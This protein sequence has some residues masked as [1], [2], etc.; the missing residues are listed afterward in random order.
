M[1]RIGREKKNLLVWKEGQ[2]KQ[3]GNW[4]TRTM[5]QKVAEFSIMAL[6]QGEERRVERCLSTTGRAEE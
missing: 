5:K 1:S 2:G 4:K 6:N 3:E